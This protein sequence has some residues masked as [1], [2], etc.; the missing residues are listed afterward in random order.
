MIAKDG[1]RPTGFEPTSHERRQA[2]VGAK[3][4]AKR[5]RR[6]KRVGHDTRGLA[7]CPPTVRVEGASGVEHLRA[8][9]VAK[10][11]RQ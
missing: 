2:R 7:R 11:A 5:D 3:L 4:G 9:T 8:E 1:E 6:E 10:I